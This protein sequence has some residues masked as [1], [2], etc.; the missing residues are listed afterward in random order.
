M[1]A[2]TDAGSAGTTDERAIEARMPSTVTTDQFLTSF[3][4]TF[5]CPECGAPSTGTCP[6][7]GHTHPEHRSDPDGGL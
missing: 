4:R 5:A 2:H 6:E 1:T 7:C 3:G